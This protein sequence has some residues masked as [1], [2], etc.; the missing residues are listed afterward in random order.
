MPR[1]SPGLRKKG[2][3]WQISYYD[4]WGRRRWEVVGPSYRDALKA[5]EQR[6]AD[7]RA[8]R[9]GWER[10]RKPVTLGAFVATHWRSEVAIAFKPSTLRVYEI[11]LR[12]HLLPFFGDYPL[13]AITRATVKRFIAEKARQQRQPR[14]RKNPNPRRATL[15]P[16][17]IK[18]VVALLGSILEAATVDYNLLDANPLRGILR[19]TQFPTDAHRL[20]DPRLRILEPEDF[21][22]AL[23]G[24]V[25][26]AREM[27]L[28]AALTGLRW[29]ELVALRIDEDVDLRRNKLRVTR[30]LYRRTPQTPK[31]RQSVREVDLCPTT[32][33]I[34]QSC[35]R[36][37]GWVFSPDGVTPIGDG[38]WV[39]RQWHDAQV[40]A[41][42][43]A[44]ITWHDLRHQ[45]VSLL[46]AAGKHPK[47]ISTQAGHA[48][49]GFTMDRYGT[50]FETLPIT[51]VEWVDDLL[52]G[53]GGHHRGTVVDTISREKVKDGGSDPVTDRTPDLAERQ[54]NKGVW[55]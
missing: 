43:R 29:G 25:P 42:V 16:K 50:L 21:R 39:K 51:P 34:L 24:M 40:K 2:P 38:H 22:R 4:Q 13:P 14:S 8:G 1:Q 54:V 35:A 31:T 41:G 55:R 26:A 37:A 9:F 45:Y 28:M 27:V 15:A 47:Y 33:Q 5:R 18:N 36:T 30:S 44:S 17:T 49:A 11:L 20:A 48:S 46:I 6:L 52:L 19:R 7:V 12:H 53:T 10:Q 3:S 23:D 32:R